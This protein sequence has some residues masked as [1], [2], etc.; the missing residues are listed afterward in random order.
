MMITLLK[1][2]D[3]VTVHA[4]AIHRKEALQALEDKLSLLKPPI[5]DDCQQLRISKHFDSIYGIHPNLN[6]CQ[7]ALDATPF[8]K[9]VLQLIPVNKIRAETERVLWH[10]RLGYHCDEYLYSAHK[11]INGVQ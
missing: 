1:K 9:L 8:R 5:E 4:V 11:F 3:K 6:L 2:C 10:Q 7:S